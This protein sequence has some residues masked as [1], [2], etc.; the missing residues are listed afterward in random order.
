[1]IVKRLT[2]L[3]AVLMAVLVAALAVYSPARAQSGSEDQYSPPDGSTYGEEV[4]ATGVLEP[5]GLAANRSDITHYITDE[6]SG[7]LWG[8]ISENPE[9]VLDPYNGQRVT[10]SGTDATVVSPGGYEQFAIAVGGVEPA[11]GDPGDP[12]KGLPFPITAEECNALIAEY[13]LPESDPAISFQGGSAL[14]QQVA[15]C[16]S[17]GLLAA[18]D[19]TSI[20]AAFAKYA[21]TSGD[22]VISRAEFDAYFDLVQDYPDEIDITLPVLFKGYADDVGVAGLRVDSGRSGEPCVDGASYQVAFDEETEFYARQSGDLVPITINDLGY[23]D[24]VEI[25]YFQVS[26]ELQQQC[27]TPVTAQAV[28]VLHSNTPDAPKHPAPEHPAPEHPA[29][30]DTTPDDPAPESTTPVATDGGGSGQQSHP[31][32]DNASKPGGDSGA[33][34][35][36]S[37]FAALGDA[38]N[39]L[40]DTGGASILVGLA[41]AALASG[42]GLLAY[43]KL[44]R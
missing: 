18:Q 44:R 26:D 19:E 35:P 16:Q 27:P 43:R 17:M 28:I 1:M 21:D 41:G 8:L 23:G 6:A 32:T 39:V 38:A 13:G 40:P 11:G 36:A 5:R 2:T 10:V 33:S 3:T 31:A 9:G 25:E 24:F 4:A 42:G 30:G 34:S 20:P 7:K 14:A 29:P 37:A 15:F 12:G 22:G